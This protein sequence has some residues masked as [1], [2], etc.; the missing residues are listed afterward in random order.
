MSKT[1]RLEAAVSQLENTV[2]LM[3]KSVNQHAEILQVLSVSFNLLNEKAGITSEEIKNALVKATMASLEKI[4]NR[5]AG[6]EPTVSD[7]GVGGS[8]VPAPEIDRTDSG[9]TPDG[10]G[11]VES[12][13]NG[14]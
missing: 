7:S 3:R 10:S 13:P 6:T 11:D 9:S 8:N 5:S 14:N 1:E 12:S 2:E 4:S